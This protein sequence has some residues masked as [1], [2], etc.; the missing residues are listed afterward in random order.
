VV[1]GGRVCVDTGSVEWVC[2]VG[3]FNKAPL[4]IVW[5]GITYEGDGA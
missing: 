3:V 2:A 1:V 5:Y 4:M